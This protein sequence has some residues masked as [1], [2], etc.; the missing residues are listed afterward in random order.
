MHSIRNWY[1]FLDLQKII[2]NSVFKIK[3]Q[4]QNTTGKTIVFFMH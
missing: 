3:Q 4:R 2:F 1:L